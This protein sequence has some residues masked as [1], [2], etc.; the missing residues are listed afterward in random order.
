ME[1]KNC[2]NRSSKGTYAVP[3]ALCEYG[4]GDD[5]YQSLSRH[6]EEPVILKR[7]YALHD[8]LCELKS[9][10]AAG[11]SGNGQRVRYGWYS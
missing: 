1:L 8:A 5:H 3:A 9:N 7:A 6:E 10:R 11:A 4:T 2:S